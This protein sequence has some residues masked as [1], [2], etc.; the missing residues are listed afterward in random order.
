MSKTLRVTAPYVTLK[1][2]DPT[3]GTVL[4]G[5]Y[6]G[7]IVENVDDESAQ[8]HLASGLAEVTEPDAMPAGPPLL[9]P[10]LT[11]PDEPAGNASREEWAVYARDFKGATDADLVDADGKELS[12]NELRDR[13]ATPAE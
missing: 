2:V 10:D 8:H 5:F 7:A 3:R 4:L 9:P 6:E 1:V 11:A 12:R 13:Y